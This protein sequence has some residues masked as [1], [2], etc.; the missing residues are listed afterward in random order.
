[1][2][3]HSPRNGP[4]DHRA[5]KRTLQKTPRKPK[6]L[7]QMPK[8]RPLQPE[9]PHGKQPQPKTPQPPHPSVQPI[10]PK[11]AESALPPSQGHPPQKT[12]GQR[13]HNPQHQWIQFRHSRKAGPQSLT[14]GAP[15]KS[16]HDIKKKQTAPPRATRQ[17]ASL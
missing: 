17:R 14:P 5:A 12:P 4:H 16:C 15:P 7:P 3:Q 13:R 2:T 8:A 11:D 1:M 9:I 10:T 6:P